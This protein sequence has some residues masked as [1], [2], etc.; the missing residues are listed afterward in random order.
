M[1]L[2]V[3]TLSH[4]SGGGYVFGRTDRQPRFANVVTQF[5]IEM[6]TWTA[7]TKRSHVEFIQTGALQTMPA[8]Y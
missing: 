1:S 2:I 7:V 6:R 8:S 3:Q 4:F 5:K